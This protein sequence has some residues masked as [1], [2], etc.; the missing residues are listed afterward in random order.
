ME[1]IRSR[2]RSPLPRSFRPASEVPKKLDSSFSRGWRPVSEWAVVAPRVQRRKGKYTPEEPDFKKLERQKLRT[3]MTD[4][5]HRLADTGRE[6]L[7]QLEQERLSDHI[8]LEIATITQGVS[9]W[10]DY[11]T[12]FHPIDALSFVHRSLRRG[13]T[14][15]EAAV[16]IKI[17]PDKNNVHIKYFNR[18]EAFESLPVLASSPCSKV[19]KVTMCFALAMV[20]EICLS[21]PNMHNTTVSL[22]ADDRGSGKLLKY[23]ENEYGFKRVPGR[24][25]MIVSLKEALEQCSRVWETAR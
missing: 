4:S 12:L 5:I 20:G 7:Y 22:Y 10:P 15:V 19:A 2:F 13:R 8:F 3:V 11:M 1:R 6:M 17:D 21:L 25:D 14:R 24:V 9:E 23:Y 16:E 18:N